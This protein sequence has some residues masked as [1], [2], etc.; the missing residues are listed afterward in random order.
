MGLEDAGEG[1]IF[2]IKCLLTLF[3][4]IL[5]CAGAGILGFALWLRYNSGYFQDLPDVENTS[6][7][8]FYIGCYILMG[9]G[10]VIMLVGILGC[11]G[12]CKESMCLLVV[13]F[14]ILFVI[15]CGEIGGS[16][17]CY[18]LRDDLGTTLTDEIDKWV[19][20][21]YKDDASIQ[22]AVDNIQKYLQCC[23]AH[24]PHDYPDSGQKVPE[25]CGRNCTVAVGVCTEEEAIREVGCQDKIT[26][27]VMQN[28]MVLAGVCIAVALAQILAMVLAIILCRYIWLDEHY[29]YESCSTI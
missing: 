7:E 26:S 19:T 25:S 13:Y 5:G 11:C 24:G 12:A 1:C 20:E 22:L 2:C 15:F 16:V 4:V 3:N 6:F 27:L 10:G 18:L 21:K 17:W 9:A 23:G 28:L 29:D 14:V 8:A